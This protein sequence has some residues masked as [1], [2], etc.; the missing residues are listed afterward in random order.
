[1]RVFRSFL[2]HKKTSPPPAAAA[3]VPKAAEAAGPAPRV[4]QVSLVNAHL[5]LTSSPRLNM[6]TV[7]PAEVA[8]GPGGM[9]VSE[10]LPQ[11]E[12][13]PII[14][15]DVPNGAT[16]EVDLESGGLTVSQFKGT[17]RARLHGGAA[18][19]DDVEGQ[20]RIVNG[21]GAVVF[22]RVSGRLDV[23]TAGGNVAA[24]QIKGELQAVSD[25]GSISVEDIDGPLAVRSTTGSIEASH[26]TGVARLTTR[27]GAVHVKG[28][29]RQ[30][31]VR[32]QSGDVT[33]D[34]SIVDHTTIDTFKGRVEVRL[35]QDS[36]TRIEAAARRGLVRTER[37]ALAP[38]SS[39]RLVRSMVGGGRARL[40]IT[41]GMGVIEITGPHRS[42]P[43]PLPLSTFV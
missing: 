37:I 20:I 36:D 40:R 26:L 13:H 31:T 11:V 5:V 8:S 43:T 25:A 9:L 42:S 28:A 27:T 29:E 14:K 19:V 21:K 10:R 12:P 33:L 18:R 16:V 39:R 15:L 35:G 41:T 4:T 22:K 17:L 34:Q 32:T 3:G 1:V 7:G 6:H 2:Q 30:L 23:L 24:Q 38:G